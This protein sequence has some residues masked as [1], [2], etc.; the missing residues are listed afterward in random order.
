M[1]TPLLL[2]FWN[3]MSLHFVGIIF[4]SLCWVL[5]GLIPSGN[6]VLSF[7]FLNIVILDVTSLMSLFYFHFSL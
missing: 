1:L 4:P 6:F 7:L 3:F 2:V 5:R